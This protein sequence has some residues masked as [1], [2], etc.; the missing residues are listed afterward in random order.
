MKVQEIK[1]ILI[2]AL[3][4]S[5]ALLITMQQGCGSSESEPELSES[6]PIVD[7][8]PLESTSLPDTEPP[9]IDLAS[10]PEVTS[11]AIWKYITQDEPYTEWNAFP[12]DRIPEFV[13]WKDGEDYI[14]PAPRSP[15][16]TGRLGK[17]Y[18]N[19]IALPALNKEPRDFPNGSI[20]IWEMYTIQGG[21]VGNL[22][23]ISGRYKVE[24]ST[25]R[26]NDWVTFGYWSNG[27][28]YNLGFGPVFGTKTA[29]YSCHE[30]SENDYMWV[31][32]PELDPSYTNVPHWG[33]CKPRQ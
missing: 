27:N 9:A 13:L 32:S 21:A 30:L 3:A 8:L 26:D 2:I 12:V 33:D 25:E 17:I 24:G 28:L 18:L 1:A 29:C 6:N 14:L 4:A 23:S 22:E 10:L 19:D 11:Q 5:Y 7:S 15:W 20:I 31:D 16:G